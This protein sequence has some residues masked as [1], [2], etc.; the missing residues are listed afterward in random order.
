MAGNKNSDFD[1]NALTQKTDEHTKILGQLEKRVGTNENFGKTFAEA[2]KDSK[3]IESSI[4]KVVV[5]QLKNDVD[6]KK[7]V[8]AVV[9]GIDSR[10]FKQ[11]MTGL[12][13][14][15]IWIVSLAV[16]AIVGAFIQ[17]KFK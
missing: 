10:T 13:K 15:V 7:A 3:S 5:D 12:G 14:I 17:S 8:E 9:T 11:Q 1:P 6:T 16:A 4:R 2:A